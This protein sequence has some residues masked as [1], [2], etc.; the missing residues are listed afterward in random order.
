MAGGRERDIEREREREL[1]KIVAQ[2]CEYKTDAGTVT[3]TVHSS[4][5]GK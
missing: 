5:A 2:N 3:A 1:F 4:G